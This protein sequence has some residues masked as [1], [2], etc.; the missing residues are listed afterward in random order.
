MPVTLPD[1]QTEVLKYYKALRRDCKSVSSVSEMKTL[2]EAFHLINE[3]CRRKPPRWGKLSVFHAVEVA[4]ITVNE[5]GLG[6]TGVIAALLSEYVDDEQFTEEFIRERFGEKVVEILTGI[7]KISS[8]KTDKPFSHAENFRN[9]IITL[10]SDIRVIIIKLSERLYL[11]RNLDYIPV[12][13]RIVLASETSYIYAPLAHRMGLYNMMSE[14]ED[15]TMKYVEPD[16]YN[17]ISEKLKLTH[18]ARN[19]FIREFLKPIKNELENQEIKADIKARVKAISSIWRKMKKQKVDFD[20]VY[21]KFA[22]RIIIDSPPSSEKTDCWKVY[23]I[24][25]DFYQPNPERMRDWISVPKSNGYESLHATVV[26][27]GGEWVE[28]QIRSKRMDEIAEKGLAAHWK[29]KGIKGE[30]GIDDW[31][32]KVREYLDNQEDDPASLLDD[33]KLNLYNKEIFVF[34][35]KGDLKKFPEGA[36]VLDFAF[37][38]H[39]AI[40]A[41]CSG[42]RING[43]NVPIRHKLKNGDKVEIIRSKNQKPN[44][45]WLNYVATSKAKS[46]IRIALKEEKLKE[47]E[48]GKEILKRRF[49]NWKLEFQDHYIRKLLHY[50]KFNDAVDLYYHI[51]TEKLDLLEIKNIL[52]ETEREDNKPLPIQEEIIEKI[53]KPPEKKS[54]DYLIIDN[55][56]VN[57]D[58]HLAK[59]CNP[60]FGDPIFGFVTRTSGITIHRVNCPNAP[61]LISRYGYRVVKAKWTQSE[62]ERSFPATLRITGNDDVSIISNISGVISKDTK[63]N[64]RSFNMES[65]D[66]LFEGTLHL[67]VRDKENLDILIKKLSK[68]KG[69]LHVTRTEG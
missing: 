43:R 41:S 30:K 5:A 34:T 29:Y 13:E 40:G 36:T 33:L 62:G 63:V 8:V 37:D 66:G 3:A 44:I 11:M 12:E 61:Q 57:I 49:K 39:S 1:T 27:P 45:D 6:G 38:I 52:T 50:Y 15:L 64:M 68:V 14:M 31:L 56:L 53:I 7:Q 2:K 60:I 22:I 65:A 54:E 47:A 55:R 58:Y 20:E 25:T 26:V 17:S 18:S 24:I 21:D 4:R 32:K 46:K 42:A 59:C 16:A 9:L 69:V 19:K 10:A 35:P 23:S 28:I 48:N 51:A 67:F